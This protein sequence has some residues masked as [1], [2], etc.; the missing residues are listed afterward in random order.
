MLGEAGGDE[1]AQIERAWWLALSRSPSET[2]RAAA[3]AHLAAQ[4]EHLASRAAQDGKVFD[5]DAAGRQVLASLC[6][7][8]FNLNEFIYVD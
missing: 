2:E 8:L 7:V 3:V 4:R 5:A 6:H 1:A